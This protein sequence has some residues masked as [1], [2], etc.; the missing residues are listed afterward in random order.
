M[1]WNSSAP[2]T[3]TRTKERCSASMVSCTS[4][5]FTNGG[6]CVGVAGTWL[7]NVGV[8][9]G[10]STTGVATTGRGERIDRASRA[11][12][13]KKKAIKPTKRT[14]LTK[15]SGVIIRRTRNH[16]PIA[17]G[18][19]AAD[20]AGAV[21]SS[22]RDATGKRTLAC[23]RRNSFRHPRL[24]LICNACCKRSSALSGSRPTCRA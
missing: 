21:T 5:K 15:V 10:P 17:T 24:S 12:P 14:A 3:V 13:Q 22:A 18:A 4:E 7:R 16:G 23:L 1:P 19:L 9:V 6:G 11:P 8:M 20:V 2:S